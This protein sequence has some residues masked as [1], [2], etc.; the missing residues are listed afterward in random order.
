MHF[1]TI[2]TVGPLSRKL[3]HFV[4]VQYLSYDKHIC[5]FLFIIS[6]DELK[7]QTTGNS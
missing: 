5:A 7:L 6:Y 2:L 1:Y 3:S 4:I